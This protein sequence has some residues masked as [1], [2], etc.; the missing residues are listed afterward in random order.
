MRYLVII[1]IC[2]TFSA[3]AQPVRTTADST[4]QPAKKAEVPTTPASGGSQLLDDSTKNVYGP[5][6]TRWRTQTQF[7]VNKRHDNIIDTAINNYHRWTFV[8]QYNNFLHDLGNNGTAL[9]P[10]FPIAPAS[11][12]VSPGFTV[13]SRYF[14]DEDIKYFN[15]KSPY[16]RMY[17][18]W[19]GDGR[20]MTRVEFSRNI[21]P[22][23]NFGFNY[24]P[25]L[26]DK[27]VQRGG[28][29][30]RQVISHYYDFHTR[31]QTNDNRYTLL[32][33]YKRVRHRVNETGGVIT[34]RIAG[35]DSVYA[36]FF[37]DNIRPRLTATS[38]LEQHNQ[39]NVFQQFEVSPR[40]Q[41]YH[42]L[43]RGMQTNWLRSD[44][45]KDGSYFDNL[46]IDSAIVK[47]SVRFR[48]LQNEMGIKGSVGKL[49]YNGYYRI[50]SYNFRYK[51][52]DADTL[53]LSRNAD[54]HFVGGRLT[55]HF[56]SLQHVTVKGEQIVN[57]GLYRYEG[58]LRSRWLDVRA[59]TQLSRPSFMQLAY[60][61]AFDF[62]FNE[63][64]SVKTT[65]GAAFAK[66]TLGPLFVAAGATYTAF[67]NYIYFN[68]DTFPK[69]TQR[70]LPVQAKNPVQF[71][72]PEFRAEL[73]L[74]K[75][76]Y[77]RPQI[78]LS[79]VLQDADSAL[80]IPERFV[81]HQVTYESYLFK[82]AI[83]VQ[84]GVDFHWHSAYQRMGYDP[85]IQQFYVQRSV[86][87]PAY[88]LTD[89]FINGKI[90]RGRFFVKYH[91]LLQ[92]FTG[93]GYLASAVYPAM[94]NIL[95]FGF[96]MLLFD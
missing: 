60:R 96:D 53:P 40:F 24:R 9:N 73:R 19:G 22:Q 51:Y 30:D 17:L 25:I 32:A 66:A 12:G 89:V 62:W 27:N 3:F 80:R 47:D 68:E 18:V 93:Q 46:E 58:A 95:D 69:T 33:N 70:V 85:A 63:F 50:R 76:F 87:A 15:T 65:S 61:G 1:L 54:E 44:L 8:Q 21:T 88:L 31:L 59:Q 82:N 35:R 4:G 78:I 55:F 94:S 83:Y 79:R 14:E 48:F 84:I 43:G 37:N 34:A 41:A 77:V 74:F 11:I 45:V 42:Q 81:N 67:D 71:F 2:S 6:T 23:W 90:K 26:T 28:R 10:V 5:A 13:Y 38:S 52:L 86:A 64:T 16:T 92:L 49:F 72:Q 29:G 36:D 39:I 7:F 57:G 91:N 75:H 56:D 20:A